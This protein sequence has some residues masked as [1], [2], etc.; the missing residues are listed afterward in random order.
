MKLSILVFALIGGA[1]CLAQT[2]PELW[3]SG[4]V[5]RKFTKKWSAEASMNMRFYEFRKPGTLYPEVSVTY[6]IV[7]GIKL[8]TDYRLV[9]EENLYGNYTF[10]NRLNFNADFELAYTGFDLGFRVRYQ[11]S[12]TGLRSTETFSP[13]FD[14]AIRLKPSV[15][16]HLG[17]ESRF[18]PSMAAEWFYS[19]VHAPLGDR[20]TKYRISAGTGIDLKGPNELDLKFIFGRNINLPRNSTELIFSAGYTFEWKKAKAKKKK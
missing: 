14:Q 20:F 15:N 3:V 12:F 18:S 9:S 19:M 6:K 1:S 7:E 16:I 10:A 11:N 5:K 2:S 17:E 13:E 8:S 4:G